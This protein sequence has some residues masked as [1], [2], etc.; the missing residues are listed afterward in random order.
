VLRRNPRP[1]FGAALLIQ[2]SVYL[3]LVLVI[4]G[5]TYAALGR[6]T[7][8]T[9]Q[10]VNEITAG[11]V[12]LIG[13]AAVVPALLA[14]VAAAIV[15]GII[16]LEVSRGTIGEKL[17]FR[18][19]WRRAN[20]RIWALIGWSALLI[21]ASTIIFGALVL[22]I[23]VLV[24]TLGNA[25]IAAAV[26]V[27]LF[28]GM[29]ILVM[30]VWLSTKLTFVPSA[31]MI[32]RL[33]IG[34]AVRRSWTLTSGF[35]WRTFGI[36]ALVSVIIGIASQVVSTPL[37]LIAPMVA[38]L[39]DPQGQNGATAV[40]VTIGLTVLAV[41]ITVV[42]QAITSVVSS[43]TT[44]LLYIDLR[45]RKEGLD[46]E[47]SKFLED[48]QSDRPDARDPFLHG[49]SALARAAVVPP[50]PAPRPESGNGSPWG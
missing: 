6:I 44:A 22:I 27:G 4:S 8:S 5:V 29:G 11:S 46:L 33:S 17:T 7:A 26:L 36:L 39:V 37:T 42:F 3:L 23:V 18:E 16:V 13:L 30:F 38:A 40:A 21:L 25:G 43:A 41:V 31:L 9:S 24:A 50:V 2:G 32:E 15:Q 34:Q 19:L 12:G 45:I 20:G 1:T 49:G 14:V 47:L 48:R 10:N 35:F 28:G